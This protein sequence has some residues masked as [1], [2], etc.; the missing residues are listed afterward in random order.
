V[1]KVQTLQ[2][3]A[4]L[5]RARSPR[6]RPRGA[7][8]EAEINRQILQEIL[9]VERHTTAANCLVWAL[10]VVAAATMPI[11]DAFILPMALRLA[12][13]VNTKLTFAAMRRKLA[14]G[15]DYTRLFSR[16]L[17]ALAVGG[18]AWAA[19]LLPLLAYGE[20]HPA[21]LLAGGGTLI[22][23]AI[24]SSLLSPNPKMSSAFHGGFVVVLGLGLVWINRGNGDMY[25]LAGLA[26]LITIFTAYSRATA[27]AQRRSAELFIENLKVGKVLAEALGQAKFLAERDPL[28]GL[29]NRRALFELAGRLADHRMRHVMVL[30]LDRFKTIN[31]RFGHATGDEVLVRA[32]RVLS[33][34][35]ARLGEGK[36]VAAR[37]GGEE[38]ALIID[39]DNVELARLS[40]EGVRHAMAL[41]ARDL[42]RES[43]VTSVSIGLG[44]W[45]AGDDLGT[46]LNLAD[47]ALYHAKNNG[48]DRV[49][50]VGEENAGSPR[51]PELLR[52][53]PC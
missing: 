52:A 24:I 31:D 43:L 19:T 23:V 30:D 10:V 21:R 39:T 32:G 17:F 37:I 36:A 41:I 53:V 1:T 26:G 44:Q 20:P 51:S 45:Q 2:P 13:M 47:G 46:A 4:S 3:L 16:L 49:V 48:R 11:R 8:R 7:L 22:G 25:A 14:E 27:T 29:Y 5:K 18:M 6:A 35:A 34:T 40:A 38:F 12:V 9:E 42:N 15:G 28:T 50:V 33:E